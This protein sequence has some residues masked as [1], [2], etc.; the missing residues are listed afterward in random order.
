MV[1]SS[2]SCARAVPLRV[3]LCSAGGGEDR[4]HRVLR[5]VHRSVV[6]CAPGPSRGLCLLRRCPGSRISGMGGAAFGGF[7]ELPGGRPSVSG[8]SLEAP[9]GPV[10]VGEQTVRFPL[11]GPR[12]SEVGGEQCKQST[13]LSP[14]SLSTSGSLLCRPCQC[15]CRV[16]LLLSC[17]WKVCV[18]HPPSATHAP[19]PSLAPPSLKYGLVSGLQRRTYYSLL[20]TSHMDLHIPYMMLH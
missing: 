15:Y 14:R 7:G 20:C 1:Q 13:C 18:A 16:A 5:L 4:I 3:A 11:L 12:G 10:Y 9:G 6:A 2:L 8:E 19:V 17:Y